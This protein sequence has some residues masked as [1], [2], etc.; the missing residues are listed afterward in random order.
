MSI[1]I[2]AYLLGLSKLIGNH[3]PKTHVFVMKNQIRFALLITYVRM[4][5]GNIYGYTTY[6]PLVGPFSVLFLTFWLMQ[7]KSIK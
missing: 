6:K 1:Y 7:V 2:Y 5:H 4:H 3:H